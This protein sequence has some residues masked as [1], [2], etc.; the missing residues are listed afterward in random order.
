MILAAL[1]AEGIPV[2]VIG[3]IWEKEKG[4]K[5]MQDGRVEDLPFFSRDEL[6]R[7]LAGG[8]S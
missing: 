7:V 5:L 3:R 2:S 4:I 8:D 6:A 1:E